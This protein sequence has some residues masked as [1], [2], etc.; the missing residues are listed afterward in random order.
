MAATDIVIHPHPI[1]QTFKNLGLLIIEIS[2]SRDSFGDISITHRV[3]MKVGTSTSFS[4]TLETQNEDS[5]TLQLEMGARLLAKVIQHLDST[6]YGFF[7]EKIGAGKVEDVHF[8]KSNPCGLKFTVETATFLLFSRCE[9]I[10]S[11]QD[12]I[13]HTFHGLNYLDR[14]ELIRTLT[15]LG[16]ITNFVYRKTFDAQGK[17]HCTIS[18]LV[19]GETFRF[20]ETVTPS[21]LQP[22]DPP[23]DLE[24][25][26]SQALMKMVSEK[27]DHNAKIQTILAMIRVGMIKNFHIKQSSEAIG[28]RRTITYKVLGQDGESALRSNALEELEATYD[29]M[30]FD[31]ISKMGTG[32]G[33]YPPVVPPLW[34]LLRD[35]RVVT[36]VNGFVVEN[37]HVL[38]C[39]IEGEQHVE[40]ES[41]GLQN[42]IDKAM[43]KIADSPVKTFLDLLT[44]G[45]ISHAS[46]KDFESDKII[47]TFAFDDVQRNVGYSNSRKDL[48]TR[49]VDLAHRLMFD[50][51][52][53]TL[54]TEIHHPDLALF[55]KMGLIKKPTKMYS[56]RDN[57]L[58]IFLNCVWINGFINDLP[59][60]VPYDRPQD[61][62]PALTDLEEKLV[63]SIKYTW[64]ASGPL[65]ELMLL[66]KE[67]VIQD[68]TVTQFSA[69]SY[70][71]KFMLDGE[72]IQTAG[73]PAM[74]RPF[75]PA[76]HRIMQAKYQTKTMALLR[77]L[78]I[79]DRPT[80]NLT[81][82]GINVWCHD[83]ISG[84]T[85]I[86]SVKSASSY[87]AA[88]TE[89]TQAL[90]T[91]FSGD[92][93]DFL[94]AIQRGDIQDVVSTGDSL[95]A[96]IRGIHCRFEGAPTICIRKALGAME[97][98]TST[99]ELFGSS[100]TQMVIRALIS[101]G[102][103]TEPK[104]NRIIKPDGISL[105]LSCFRDGTPYARSG[106]I[107][108]DISNQ[109]EKIRDK[110]YDNLCFDLETSLRD[111]AAGQLLQMILVGQV[112]EVTFNSHPSAGY[113]LT[114]KIKTTYGVTK[115]LVSCATN[116]PPCRHRCYRK[117]ID[118]ISSTIPNSSSSSS[119][120]D[121]EI[122]VDDQPDFTKRGLMFSINHDHEGL[123]LVT[124]IRGSL[125]PCLD[126]AT[127]VWT[128]KGKGSFRLKLVASLDDED[129]LIFTVGQQ[130]YPG[131]QYM[132]LSKQ[133][134][135]KTIEL[136]H[137]L[138]KLMAKLD[139]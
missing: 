41:I 131:H 90:T 61:L 94:K 22:F 18:A 43:A 110:L 117:A 16:I 4:E 75:A 45:S 95:E 6:P 107:H 96:Q 98:D 46:I 86:P 77:S 113:M 56:R 54:D 82:E 129:Q 122:F 13:P 92:V 39:R 138:A 76:L 103:L 99:A 91:H 23:A 102:L 70:S 100:D 12:L 118:L 67:N 115:H 134:N 24:D 36:D 52:L 2:H 132:V 73:Y 58:M 19:V 33:F 84:K 120:S 68:L 14:F 126:P 55:Q 7:C 139:S 27:I 136:Y 20:D 57:G 62:A 104:L 74:D 21:T 72:W 1:L 109:Y 29:R 11:L 85:V 26:A 34:Y 50:K 10:K 51:F 133:G 71:I 105:D 89:L 63:N 60:L 49:G 124:E 53:A 114:L 9:K 47:L 127:R 17:L 59:H 38:I 81:S 137:R 64:A 65:R 15:N 130:Y 108:N 111:T 119:S 128:Y 88:Y 5:K 83:L 28:A 79:I 135:T 125:I 40:T 101:L 123:F 112:N 78:K 116:D 48:F 106:F 32:F 30:I 42:V 35:L 80:H 37:H 44:A 31:F 121:L 25:R 69:Y 93:G 66:L 87:E 97:N 3:I 8:P